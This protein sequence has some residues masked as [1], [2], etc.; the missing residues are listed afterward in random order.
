MNIRIKLEL[1]ISW[2]QKI[3]IWKLSWATS[4]KVHPIYFK[5]DQ[6]QGNSGYHKS[7][8]TGALQILGAAVWLRSCVR[9]VAWPPV[10]MIFNNCQMS[11]CLFYL[12]YIKLSAVTRRPWKLPVPFKCINHKAQTTRGCRC[13]RR[14]A[15]DDT[16]DCLIWSCRIIEP[17]WSVGQV[18]SRRKETGARSKSD[19]RRE[20]SKL[21]NKTG[22]IDDWRKDKTW[23]MKN[24]KKYI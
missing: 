23:P 18:I 20:E 2:I 6:V 22:N 7:Q 15:T 17:G 5:C 12:P 9:R 10:K 21:Q 3:K 4:K 19:T 14:A 1:N 8:N 24:M 11:H 16:L 13:D